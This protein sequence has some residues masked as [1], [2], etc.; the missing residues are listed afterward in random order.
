MRELRKAHI[1]LVTAT[2]G[3]AAY[4]QGIPL[5]LTQLPKRYA[6]VTAVNSQPT[7]G[8]K[9]VPADNMAYRQSET[10]AFIAVDII[11]VN[12]FGF[13]SNQWIE[14]ACETYD[15]TARRQLVVPGYSVKQTI[16]SSEVPLPV[17]TPTQSIQ[18]TVI[19]F[20]HWIAKK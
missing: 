3:I 1:E 17:E 18:R 5:D 14:W 7:L 10:Q 19:T 4:D 6:I 16:K 13:A 2:L 9:P 15:D 11:D 8:A 20:E 12:D